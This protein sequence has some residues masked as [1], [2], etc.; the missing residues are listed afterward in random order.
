MKERFEFIKT[1]L[2]V[3][4]LI[5]LVLIIVFSLFIERYLYIVQFLLLLLNFAIIFIMFYESENT[6]KRR[7]FSVSKIL[8]NEAK[9]AFD[10]AR[11]GILTYNH[12]QN[13]TWVS[14]IFDDYDL[15]IIGEKV[16]NVFPELEELFV[17]KVEEKTLLIGEDI[18]LV[19][20]FSD[21]STLFFKDVSDVIDLEEQNKNNQI[22]LGIA[23]LDNYEETTQYEEEQTIAFIDSNI[24]QEVVRWADRHDMFIRRIRQDRYLLVLNERV[25]DEINKER[26]KIVGDIRDASKKIDA[27]I[28][29]SLAFARKSESFK[30]LEDMSNKALELA[31]SRGGDQ[32]A[33]NTK[34]EGMR[35][36]GGSTEA[37]EK[38]SKVRV[39]VMAQN[40]G[41]LISQADNVLIVGHKMM[42]F[43][44]FSSA[45]GLS[46]IVKV[47]NKQ[48]HVVINMNDTEQTLKEAILNHREELA[49]SHH[50]VEHE[51][52]LKLLNEKTLLIMTDHHNL[53]QTQFEDLV[54]KASKRVI[55]DH[56][57]RTDEFEFKTVLT[58]IEA[59]ASSASELVIELFPYHRRNVVIS[60]L[61][62][63]FMYTGMLIDTNRFRNRSHSRTFQAAAE[64]RK[65]GADLAEVE[66]MLKD[67]YE[68]F[69][70]KN[71]VLSTSQLYEDI[72]VLA[73]YKDQFIPRPLMSQ[74]ADEIISVKG[75]E[76]S[77]VISYVA[78]DTVAISARSNGDLNVQSVMERMGGGGH[79]T[80]AAVQIKGR[81]INDVV[82]QLKASIDE[83][84]KESEA[85]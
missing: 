72:Y 62:A 75:I 13:I 20:G 85:S 21:E 27:R 78:E 5:E 35:Y 12:R 55:I 14:E 32:V 51:E 48:A 38:R 18:Y 15:E 40:L 43:D 26:F 4:V 7:V 41:S 45:L 52:A 33:I 11:V 3:L 82:E 8:G 47:Y 54:E 79:F 2:M 68:S 73:P 83:V 10:F 1:R 42:D 36:F 77:F 44:S 81:S 34:D 16:T 50:L 71:L 17:G 61:D 57:R 74:V 70:L 80:G 46:S 63:T 23:H 25:F 30:E 29:L 56:H 31:Q 22:V 67:E 66:Y 49:E 19:S 39:R 60:K 65:Y 6:Y 76:A 53:A 64:L 59:A 24:R 9:Y 37:I 58:Y 84:R 28:T 69:E